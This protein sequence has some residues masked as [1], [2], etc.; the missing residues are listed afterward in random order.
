FRPV[1]DSNIKGHTFKGGDRDSYFRC[2]SISQLSMEK[3]SSCFKRAG[4]RLRN[5]QAT[6]KPNTACSVAAHTGFRPVTIEKLPCKIT[7]SLWS[8]DEDGPISSYAK[9]TDT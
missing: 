9:P 7:L 2:L 1:H 8:L 5:M 6:P 4:W 3:A